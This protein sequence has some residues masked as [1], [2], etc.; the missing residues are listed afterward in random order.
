MIDFT[1]GMH[2]D[3]RGSLAAKLARAKANVRDKYAWVGILERLPESLVAL[4]WELPDLFGDMPRIW[5]HAKEKV[6]PGNER[7]ARKAM[8]P[9]RPGRRLA[10]AGPL[11]TQQTIER[12]Q[13]KR[14]TAAE[15]ELYEHAVELLECKLRCIVRGNNSTIPQRRQ[16]A[17]LRAADALQAIN[18]SSH[19]Q[20]NLSRLPHQ[21]SRPAAMSTTAPSNLSYSGEMCRCPP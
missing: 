16:R 7:S 2:P 20:S 12:M 21:A 4:Q 13:R 5:R 8:L 6:L 1:C 11:P 3:C 14:E 9:G 15:V 10:T 17:V 18:N 19:Q